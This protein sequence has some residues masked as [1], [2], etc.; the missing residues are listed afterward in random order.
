VNPM[1]LGRTSCWGGHMSLRHLTG[2]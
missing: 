1:G 2:Q